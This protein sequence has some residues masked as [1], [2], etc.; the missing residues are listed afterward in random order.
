MNAPLDNPERRR[1]ATWLA[2]AAFLLALIVVSACRAI[3]GESLGLFFG[4]VGAATVI[5]PPLFGATRGQARAMIPAAA[6]VGAALVWAFTPADALTWTQWLA[7]CIVLAA[8]SLAL[9][10]V[11][12]LLIAL[13]ATP[14][15]ASAA[16][17]CVGLLWL[18][19]PVWLSHALLTTAGDMLVTWLVPAHPLFAING[20]LIHFDAWDRLPLAYTRLTV[21]NQDVFYALPRN[22]AAATLAHV[23]V[24]MITGGLAMLIERRRVQTMSPSAAAVPAG[25]AP[26]GR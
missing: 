23:I 14:T 6:T 17:T 21:L 7:C 13:R 16:V 20:V 26:A 12:A 4:G 25:D 19:W 15:L 1:G 3:A 18:T 10:G 8:Y 24:A 9:A 22:I 2:L 11:C 5:V